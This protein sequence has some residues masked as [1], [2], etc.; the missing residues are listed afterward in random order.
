MP[1]AQLF[2][3]GRI[4]FNTGELKLRTLLEC[5]GCGLRFL[6]RVPSRETLAELYDDDKVIEYWNEPNH[7]IYQY[8]KLIESGIEFSRDRPISVLDVGC[9]T[10][11]FLSILPDQWRK[12]GVDATPQ[13]I[14]IAANKVSDADL[15]V[16]I[17]EDSSFTQNSYDLITAWD[18]MEHIHDVRRFLEKIHHLLRQGG[19]FVFETGN[20]SSAYARYSGRAWYYYSLFDHTVF[21]APHVI[22]NMTESSGFIL[23]HLVSTI[24]RQVPS[25]KKKLRSH[26]LGCLIPIYTMRG[27][28]RIT[29]SLL[30]RALGKYGTI[31]QPYVQDHMLVVLQKRET[32]HQT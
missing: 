24:H 26:V 18:V 31:P 32:R 25:L 3:N 16:G 17:F 6:E 2:P 8:H 30:A 29:H 13:A 9:N 14:A 11:S 1:N 27:R 21:Y 15:R 23:K 20:F 5:K 4:D 12:Y 10:G 7:E 28:I 19:H 22:I